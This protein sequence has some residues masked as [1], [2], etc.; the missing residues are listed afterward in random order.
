MTK[1]EKAVVFMV[2]TKYKAGKDI[3]TI[4]E[5]VH[6]PLQHVK[7]IISNFKNRNN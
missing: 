7:T 4:S 1:S 6:I 3:A 2:L 5:E